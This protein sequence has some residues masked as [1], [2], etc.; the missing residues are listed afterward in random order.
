MSKCRCILPVLY[1]N[2][3]AT[4]CYYTSYHASK[5]KKGFHIF[6][7]VI[8]FL[9]FL[10]P[11]ELGLLED[12]VVVLRVAKQEFGK[13]SLKLGVQITYSGKD[14]TLTIVLLALAITLPFVGFCKGRIFHMNNFPFPDTATALPSLWQRLPLALRP[15]QRR[16]PLP[17]RHPQS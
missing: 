4:Y 11:R 6:Y 16:R 15:P 13:P 12:V 8:F 5:T 10:V 7:F 14:Q 2:I 9:S 1:C 3:Y 17:W